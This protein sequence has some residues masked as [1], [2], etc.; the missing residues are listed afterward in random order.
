MGIKKEWIYYS[1]LQKWGFN[2]YDNA[3][4]GF[5]S[6]ATKSFYLDKFIGVGYIDNTLQTIMIYI[7]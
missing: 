2:F 5:V 6:S 7:F 1:N 4:I 3:E